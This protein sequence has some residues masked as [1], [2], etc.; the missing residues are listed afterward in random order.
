[1]RLRYTLVADGPGDACLVHP[2]NWVLRRCS[3]HRFDEFVP[4]VADRRWHSEATSGL[5]SRL[6]A[7]YSQFP[8]EI[9]FIHRDAERQSPELRYEEIQEAIERIQVPPYVPI[10]PIRM[11]EAWLLIDERAI[12]KAADNPNGTADLR[13]PPIKKLEGIPDPK[14][15]LRDCLIRASEFKGR[16]RDQFKRRMS[17]RV[18]RVASLIQD[19]APLEELPAFRRLEED[20]DRVLENIASPT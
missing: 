14:V 11:T 17:S 8:C 12:R 10:V 13:M 5:E 16:R 6:E 18:H 7:G 19:Y 3:C 1:M 20:V 9:L 2:I 4:Q 15:F